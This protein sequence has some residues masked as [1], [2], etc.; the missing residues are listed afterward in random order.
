MADALR[1]DRPAGV[2]RPRHGKG[3]REFNDHVMARATEYAE[4]TLHSTISALHVTICEACVA[5]GWSQN[6]VKQQR[7]HGWP[8]KPTKIRSPVFRAK[9]RNS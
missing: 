6:Y 3:N 7:T 8:S 1:P 9:E 4:E 5:N 2:Q